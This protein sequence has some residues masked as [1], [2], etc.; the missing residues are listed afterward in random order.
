MAK[1][2]TTKQWEVFI[3]NR[4]RTSKPGALR[5]MVLIYCLQTDEEAFHGTSTEENGVGFGKVDSEYMTKLVVDLKRT[6]RISV[7]DMAIVQNKVGK[8]WRQLMG[9]ATGTIPEPAEYMSLLR[10]ISEV[11]KKSKNL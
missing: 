2:M 11:Q 10:S 7:N 9:V 5:A 6:G 1:E 8:Y 3:K 4:C